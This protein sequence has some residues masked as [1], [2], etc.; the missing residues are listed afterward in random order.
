MS[1]W[2]HEPE[3]QAV[4][5][6][7]RTRALARAESLADDAMGCLEQI[8]RDGEASHADRRQAAV[9]ILDRAGVAGATKV[10]HSG[11]VASP[12]ASMDHRALLERARALLEPDGEPDDAGDD[13]TSH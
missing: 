1:R 8:M 13:G 7:T 9:A 3:A 4:R 10:E 2:L 6:S 5:E 12:A 11:A